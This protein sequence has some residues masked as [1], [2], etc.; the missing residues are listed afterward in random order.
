MN[1]PYRLLVDIGN[2]FVKWGRYKAN[3]DV[4]PHSCANT[5]RRRKS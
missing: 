5:R 3:L 2:T 4:P 1:E